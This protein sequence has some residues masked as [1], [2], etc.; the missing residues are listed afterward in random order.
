MGLKYRIAKLEDVP[1]NVR[2]LY[3]SEGTEFVLDA[4]GVVPKERLDEFRNNNVSLQQQLDKLKDIDPAKYKELTILQRKLEEKELID[5]GELDKVVNLRVDAMNQEFTSVKSA[6]EVRLQAADAQLNMLLVDNVVK[7]AAIKQGVIAEAVDDVVLRAK[8]TYTVVDGVPTPKNSKGEVIYGK[9]GKTPMPVDEWLQELK[10]TAK[11][12]FMGSS[13]S[14]AGGGNRG[15]IVN[16][17]NLTP[18]QKITMGLN[19]GG[20]VAKLPA[21]S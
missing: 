3:R 5:K 20:L 18:A 2:T 13:G 11:H 16:T 12:L 9:D 21:E 1:E 15:G 17:A 19:Q 6:L 4:E 8:G 10:K 14:G 7:T